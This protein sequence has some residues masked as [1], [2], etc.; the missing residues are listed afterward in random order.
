MVFFSLFI[1]S[2]QT[3]KIRH[4]QSNLSL[5]QTIK[6]PITM[7]FFTAA[8]ALIA[9]TAVV[10]AAPAPSSNAAAMQSINDSAAATLQQLQA[11]GCNYLSTLDSRSRDAFDG[12]K[13]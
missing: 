7:H 8:T 1:I 3:D 13:S 6:K 5:F 10:L 9:S 2:N 4:F 11:N 12:N